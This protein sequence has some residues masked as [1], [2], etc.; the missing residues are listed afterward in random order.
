MITLAHL[1]SELQLFL[2]LLD[3]YLTIITRLRL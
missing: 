2:A 3:F 1:G